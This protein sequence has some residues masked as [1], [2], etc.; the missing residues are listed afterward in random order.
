MQAPE[1]PVTL[2][3]PTGGRAAVAGVH[4]DD[5]VVALPMPAVERTVTTMTRTVVLVGVA[6]VFLAGILGGLAVDRALRDLRRV[7]NAAHAVASGDPS[8][9]VAVRAPRTEVGQLGESFNSMVAALE[10]AFTER[11]A[12]GERK[13]GRAHV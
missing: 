1:G 9:R 11:E 5:A 12:A 4:L 8:R 10:E 13:I 7:Q 6:V 2:D 3:T